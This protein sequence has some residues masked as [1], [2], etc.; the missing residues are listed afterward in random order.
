MCLGAHTV[1]VCV[2]VCVCVCVSESE[3]S[4]AHVWM[5]F[6]SLDSEITPMKFSNPFKTDTYM[7]VKVLVNPSYCH[8]A[9][10]PSPFVMQHNDI[11]N[12][13]SFL[14]VTGGLCT[15]V[16]IT[17]SNTCDD[18]LSVVLRP[19]L[20]TSKI[21]KRNRLKCNLAGETCFQLLQSAQMVAQIAITAWP[22]MHFYTPQSSQLKLMINNGIIGT[23]SKKL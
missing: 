3:W 18:R 16:F 21:R 15:L 22:P 5:S 17:W 2:C 10:Q 19:R 14:K 11:W 6:T 4:C 23:M 7:A 8:S 13:P 9:R 1:R 12:R 20:Y